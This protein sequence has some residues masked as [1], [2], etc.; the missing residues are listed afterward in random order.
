ML[1]MLHCFV[2]TELSEHEKFTCAVVRFFSLYLLYI[3]V[4]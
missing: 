4:H 2:H 1:V 3:Q